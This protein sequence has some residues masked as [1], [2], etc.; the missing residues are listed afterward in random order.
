MER[1]PFER[2][3]IAHHHNEEADP[4]A[5]YPD[6]LTDILS[7]EVCSTAQR[8]I[9]SWHGYCPTDLRSLDGLAAELG[10]S[11]LYYKDEGGRFGLG[12]FKALGGAYAVLRLLATQARSRTG[13][14]VSDADIGSGG[15]ADVVRDIT[16][17]TATDG[18][19][20]R[21]VAWGA[22]RFGCRCVIYI[23]AE[24]SE[25]RAAAMAAFG[26]EI[27]RVAGNYDDSVRRAAEDAAAHGWFVVSDTSYE[28]Y[29]EM[30]RQ[31]MAGYTV[32]TAEIANQLPAGVVPTHIFVQSGCG[33]LAGALCADLW[34]TLG[35]RRPR[36]FVVDP[37]RADCLF[38]SAKNSE[39]TDVHV[40]QETIMAGLSVG[41]VSLLGWQIL[42]SGADD[43][44]TITDELVGPTM[45]LLAD[46]TGGDD[47]IVAGESAVAG[48][49]ALIA[50][51]FDADLSRDLELDGNARV[52]II[53]TEGATDPEIYRS[54]VGRAPEDVA[55]HK[56]QI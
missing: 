56:S 40:T 10:L 6:Y 35:D 44:M 5:P 30:P 9:G 11:Q 19:H 42:K 13:R 23:H 53:G 45:R 28:G 54:I 50:A 38:Q 16:V 20:G 41:E 24:V 17:V 32:M 52:L 47:P 15:C 22:Q 4:N 1:D 14:E 3:I 39:P 12:S 25:G 43:F 29:A 37:D 21:S 31:V 2:A 51:R 49:A 55:S 46:G 48:L 8:V 33:G 34:R 7:D 26:A 36:F 18:N 27:V